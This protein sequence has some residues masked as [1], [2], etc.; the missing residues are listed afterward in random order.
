MSHIHGGYV[1]GASAKKHVG[2]ASRRC[3]RVQATFAFH[4]DIGECIE[5]T[6]E[7]VTCAADVFSQLALAHVEG[8]LRAHDHRC[9]ARGLAVDLH[10]PGGN[11][12]CGEGSGAHESGFDQVFIEAHV[13]LSSF[14]R[15]LAT[16]YLVQ[17]NPQSFAV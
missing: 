6:G 1:G 11:K 2:K 15:C 12:L 5:G 4:L 13:S 14:C 7:L 8:V 17:V 3:S 10:V 9:L 16:G